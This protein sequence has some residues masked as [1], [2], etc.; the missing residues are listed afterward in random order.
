MT[1]LPLKNEC[2][3][4]LVHVLHV[5]D[6]MA[7]WVMTV[8][9]SAQGD[10]T[11]PSEQHFEKMDLFLVLLSFFSFCLFDPATRPSC[12]LAQKGKDM[13]GAVL[14][15]YALGWKLCVG[16][17]VLGGEGGGTKPEELLPCWKG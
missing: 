15:A 14:R 2:V 5:A 9:C 7:L 12:I 17:G 11:S 16:G 8:I 13:E 3:F 6:A 1:R 10:N 4:V